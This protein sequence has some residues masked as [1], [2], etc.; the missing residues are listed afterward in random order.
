MFTANGIGRLVPLVLLVL[1]GGVQAAPDNAPA[2]VMR[3]EMVFDGDKPPVRGIKV[4]DAPPPPPALPP[5]AAPVE[6]QRYITM[7]QIDKSKAEDPHKPAST[8]PAPASPPAAATKAPAAPVTP[9]A[10][11]P[12][13]KP[14]PAPVQELSRQQRELMLATSGPRRAAKKKEPEPDFSHVHWGYAG[15]G[16]PENWDKLGPANA[17]CGK[18]KRQSPID[19]RSGIKVDLEPIRFDYRLSQIR[20]VDN[21]HTIQVEV[22]EGST[23]TV[24]G[25]TYPLVQFHFHR[26][27]EERIN[28]RPFDMVVH[29]VHK[30]FDN[31]LAVVAV[32]MERGSEH[33]IIQTVWNYIPLEVGM[34][35]QPPNVV[36]DLSRLLPTNR[37]Y[38]TYMGSLTTPPCSENVLWMVM[39]QPIQVS[40]QQIA[41][42]ARLYPHNARPIQS[43]H[44]RLV[45]ESR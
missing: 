44:D 7:P 31:N 38:Y 9:V 14:A 39:K 27:A 10:V 4:A 36:V 33:P 30:D 12:A 34:D 26:P 40:Q 28:G 17:A 15:L 19:I 29:L 1:A 24:T 5:P 22:S 42:F 45:K 37:E 25:R 3:A 6:R 32:L 16:A 2:R 11:A 20:V 8:A 35:S 43:T 21:G 13:A 41:T 18:G 23:I